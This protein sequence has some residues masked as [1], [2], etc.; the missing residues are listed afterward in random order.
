MKIYRTFKNDP[1]W[2]RLNICGL[3]KHWVS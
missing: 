3:G 1:S 2:E